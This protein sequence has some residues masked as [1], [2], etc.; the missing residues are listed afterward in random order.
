MKNLTSRAAAPTVSVRVD[1]PPALSEMLDQAASNSGA[2][3]RKVII[4]ALTKHLKRAGKQ[5]GA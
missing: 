5:G 1:L 4:D 3:K 2:T